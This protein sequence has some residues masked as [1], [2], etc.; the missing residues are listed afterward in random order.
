[1]ESCIFLF[2]KDHLDNYDQTAKLSNL[3]ITFSLGT[4]T[5]PDQNDQKMPLGAVSRDLTVEYSCPSDRVIAF[6]H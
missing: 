3:V 2:T 4:A 1:M 5:F 6:D